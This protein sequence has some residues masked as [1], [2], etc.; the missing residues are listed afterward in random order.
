MIFVSLFE[1]RE[2]LLVFGYCDAD[3]YDALILK[4]FNQ[5]AE[6]GAIPPL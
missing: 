1:L 6:S 5:V 4:M 2:R 3:C